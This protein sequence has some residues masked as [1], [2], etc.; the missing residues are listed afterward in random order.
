MFTGIVE[1]T[2]LITDVK[3]EGSNRIFRITTALSGELK[4]DQSVAHDGVC[5]TVE[6][7]DSNGYQVTAVAETLSKT[8]LSAWEKGKWVNLERCLLMPARL[9][10]H[11]VL[12]HVD[13]VGTCLS[14]AENEGS[15]LYR[16]EFP[17]S[18]CPLIV[19]KGSVSLNG[20]S[21]T[22]F[23]VTENEFSVAVIPYT[24][25]HTTMQWLLPGDKVNLEFDILGKYV[26]RNLA[27]LK[28]P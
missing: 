2:G 11:I 4:P 17:A 21:L 7:S 20:I 24:Y 28:R 26:Q 1:T 23:D 18:F 9:D 25:I 27:Y 13:A 16:L 8:T 6:Q 10:G 15:W 19:E 22:V 14:V 12:G 3:E 5:L